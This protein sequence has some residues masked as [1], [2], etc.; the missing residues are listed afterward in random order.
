LCVQA[1]HI[2]LTQPLLLG[3]RNTEP[4]LLATRYLQSVSESSCLTV[5]CDLDRRQKTFLR[6]FAGWVRC[7]SAAGGRAAGNCIEGALKFA[8]SLRTVFRDNAGMRRTH[9]LA[10][11]RLLC[12]VRIA[13]TTVDGE[14]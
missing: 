10:D 2:H 14:K 8:K 7:R 12:T 1:S 4:A 11:C 13:T 3:L 5:S 9:G 6:E